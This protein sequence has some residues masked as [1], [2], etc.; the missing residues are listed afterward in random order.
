MLLKFLFFSP[1]LLNYFSFCPNSENVTY[2]NSTRV[3]STYS[4]TYALNYRGNHSHQLLKEVTGFCG[5]Y[6]TQNRMLYIARTRYIF[7]YYDNNISGPNSSSI[8][9]KDTAR[10]TALVP[11]LYMSCEAL[12]LDRKIETLIKLDSDC[13]IKPRRESHTTPNQPLISAALLYTHNTRKTVWK[14]TIPDPFPRVST[15]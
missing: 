10:N 6:Y 2:K 12:H 13:V 11:A 8:V 9:K 1:H 14:C 4:S 3:L 5:S 7:T 15:T